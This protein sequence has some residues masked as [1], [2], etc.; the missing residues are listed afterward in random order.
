MRRLK[1][2]C[3]LEEDDGGRASG[4]ICE[5]PGVDGVV[6]GRG[7]PAGLPRGERGGTGGTLRLT[8]LMRLLT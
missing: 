5:G 8:R 1:L 7:V 4:R 6:L 3:M 2:I